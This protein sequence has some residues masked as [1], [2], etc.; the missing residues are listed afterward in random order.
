M[1]PMD[2][3]TGTH[4]CGDERHAQYGASACRL[5]NDGRH[6]LI[7]QRADTHHVN[8]ARY[9][10]L[11]EGPWFGVIADEDPVDLRAAQDIAEARKP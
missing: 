1:A 10:G 7:A 4:T 5:P 9:H 3:G 6:I 2:H 8:G 11:S